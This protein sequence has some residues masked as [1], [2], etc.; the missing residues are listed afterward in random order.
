M[1]YYDIIVLIYSPLCDLANL[2]K[3]TKNIY[4]IL[5]IEVNQA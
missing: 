3:W 5:G 4:K 1:N 2:Y